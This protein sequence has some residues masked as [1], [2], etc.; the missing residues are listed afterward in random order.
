[1]S[2]TWLFPSELRTVIP[3]LKPQKTLF[4]LNS[5][6]STFALTDSEPEHPAIKPAEINRAT[7]KDL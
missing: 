3:D 6:N 1:M 7:K 2:T 5:Q 4:H